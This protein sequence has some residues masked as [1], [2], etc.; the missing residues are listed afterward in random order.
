[1][2]LDG[3]SVSLKEEKIQDWSPMYREIEKMGTTP[4]DS[5]PSAVGFERITFVLAPDSPLIRDSKE[6]LTQELSNIIEGREQLEVRAKISIQ[7]SG[8]AENQ[9]AT[10]EIPEDQLD[11]LKHF[12]KNSAGQRLIILLSGHIIG[13]PLLAN[14]IVDPVFQFEFLY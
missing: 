3:F 8:S 4:Q 6:R 11:R 5:S 12:T 9:E 1:M 14:Q 7:S 10:L 2:K 13:R